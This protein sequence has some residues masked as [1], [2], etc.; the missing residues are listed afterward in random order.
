SRARN[1]RRRLRRLVSADVPIPPLPQ[2]LV[3]PVHG[4]ALARGQQ[5]NARIDTAVNS[6]SSP[7]RP[8][9][10]ARITRDPFLSMVVNG[11]H[12]PSFVVQNL[13]RLLGCGGCGPAPCAGT[14][15][16][17]GRSNTSWTMPG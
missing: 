7:L 3:R 10:A 14:G 5:E 2:P 15:S 12:P 11:T 9:A 4:H 13:L 16:A 17:A 6:S 8:G 1:S